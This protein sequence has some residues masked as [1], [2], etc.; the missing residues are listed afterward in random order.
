MTET[1]LKLDLNENNYSYEQALN[2]ISLKGQQIK[3]ASTR[4]GNL[5][6]GIKAVLFM[7]TLPEL[8][9]TTLILNS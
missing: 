3:Y 1:D 8:V 7:M 4:P 9:F 2:E 6:D 5:I